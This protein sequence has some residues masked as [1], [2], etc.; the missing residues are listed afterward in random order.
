M[1]LALMDGRAWTVGELAQQAGVARNTASEHLAGLTSAGLVTRTKQ[2]RHSYIRLA[3]S[4][5]AEVIE[6]ISRITD[7]RPAAPSL[8][9]HRHDAELAAGRTCYGHLAGRLG[10]DLAERWQCTGLVTAD[11]NIT[12]SGR[13]WFADIGLAVPNSKQPALRP[14]IDWTERRPHAAGPLGRA[15]TKL[16]FSQG[17]VVRGHHPRAAR[18]TAAGRSALGIR[19]PDAWSG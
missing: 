7:V 19:C 10:V 4:E 18:L 11:W 14:C 15:V 9:A 6:M 5:V 8:R 13:R 1:A 16:A 2:G 17:W 3:G 12:A